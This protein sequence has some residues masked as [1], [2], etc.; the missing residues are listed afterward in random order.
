MRFIPFLALVAL[1]ACPDPATDG[2]IPVDQTD[3]T[4][5]TDGVTDDSTTATTGDTGKTTKKPTGICA[6]LRSQKGSTVLASDNLVARV[7]N[8]DSGDVLLLE[9]GTYVVNGTL[10]IDKPLTIRS[11]TN[12]AADV[13]IDGNYDS[14]NLFDIEAD[15]VTIAHVTL[16]Q[17]KEHTVSIVPESGQ[18]IVRF[19]MHGVRVLNSGAYGVFVNAGRQVG[20]KWEWDAVDTAE[21]SCS[22]FELEDAARIRLAAI[23][24]TG[25]I[26][27]AGG[28]GWIVRDNHIENFFCEGTSVP[29]ALR[30]WRG[31]RDTI[32]T[33]NTLIDTPVGIVVGQSQD[34]IGREYADADCV[35]SNGIPQTVDTQVTNNIVSTNDAPAMEVG[36]LAESSCRSRIVHNSIHSTLE[37]DASVVHRYPTT[38]GLLANNLMSDTSRRFVNSALRVNTNYESAPDTVWAF[39]GGEDYR[40]APGAKG[41]IDMGSDQY[42]GLVPVDIDNEPRDATPDIGADER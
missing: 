34:D 8:A 40:L 23:C 25:A 17:S 6:P 15:D 33:R 13:I 12:N 20:K 36:I 10:T 30:F 14:G 26:D 19:R 37:G 16:T 35:E 2:T 42:L 21:I 24:D 4:D 41:A 38:T 39:V 22:S 29:H 9:P 5:T 32:I 27:V 3:T 7:I 18:T 11:T 28:R 1:A 31:S